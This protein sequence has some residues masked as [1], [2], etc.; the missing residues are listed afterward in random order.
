MVDRIISLLKRKKGGMSFQKLASQLRLSPP[1]KQ[2]LKKTLRELESQGIVFR[3]K[4]R[5]FV[6]A[7]PHLITG[8]FIRSR[9]EYGF[10]A[11]QKKPGE[12]IF[13]PP[14]RSGGAMHGDTVEVLYKRRGKKGKPEGRIL[15]VLEKGKERVI[16][17]YREYGGQPYFLPLDAPFSEE[18][19]VVVS[20]EFSP[21]PGMLVEVERKTMGLTDILG[22]PDEPG[23]DTEAVM[24][25][26]GLRSS[27][28]PQ[29]LQEAQSIPF[30]VSEQAK[31]GRVDHRSWLTVTI[32]GEEA[33]DFDDAVSVRKLGNGGFLLGVHIADVSHYVQPGTHLDEEALER[34]TS[35]YFPDRTL[36]MLPER[37]SNKLCSLR[38]AE[39]K[40]A[41]SVILKID[42]EGNVVDRVF[43]PSLIRTEA[44]MTYRSV[45]KIFLGEEEERARFSKL[46]PDLMIMRDLARLLKRKRKEEG[47]LD[48]DITEP[49]LIYRE[50]N[51]VSVL[52]LQR[53]EAHQVIE[54][55][56]VASNEAVA[57]YLA[58]KRVPLLYRIHPQPRERDLA[59][60]RKILPHFGVYLPEKKKIESKDIQHA[61][62]QAEGKPYEK[63][64]NLQ[65]LKSLSLA[66]YSEENKGHF[67][68]AKKI[69]THFTSPIRRYPDLV[70]HRILKQ[71]L[72]QEKPPWSS[73]SSVAHR[74]S[75]QEQRADEAER[76]L[77]EW[78]IYQFLK[79]KLG[80]EMEGTVIDISKAGLEVELDDYLVSG[81]V[82]FSDLADDHYV[83]RS[84]KTVVGRRT[85]R[86]LEM[87]DRI[88]G[89]LASVDPVF[90]RLTLTLTS[91]KG[92]RRR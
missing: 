89:I 8:R 30:P 64:V 48:F 22:M 92:G 84:E 40:L 2:R 26:Y 73:L 43:Q 17:Q 66:V 76:E 32:D 56:M 44:R 39:D 68:L 11:V 15:R 83:K 51:I 71:V 57:S 33:Q 45:Y 61:V 54:E 18:L 23:V 5:Y 82:F 19:P 3:V 70:V 55:F 47:S 50:G 14:G 59:K 35:V 75:E 42:P 49:E 37:L 88:K 85:G 86:K 31:E 52:P 74:C 90:R 13:I 29:S 65:I 87:G 53:N 69:Y 38:P 78:K 36:A 4:R 24:R 27:F 72:K 10:V 58:E 60:L 7:S 6:P 91:H 80:E 1:Q 9:K 41:F 62:E 12:D 67:G 77:L 20:R 25:K 21:V 81:T 28:S 79:Q 63:F 34:G 16:G 46:V